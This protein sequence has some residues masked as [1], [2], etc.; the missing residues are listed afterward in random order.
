[1]C[2]ISSFFSRLRLLIGDLHSVESMKACCRY[3]VESE[4][5]VCHV[6]LR[7]SISKCSAAQYS[8]MH[9]LRSRCLLPLSC[10][11]RVI[12]NECLSLVHVEYLVKV[13][14]KGKGV[15]GEGKVEDKDKETC[16]LI[17]RVIHKGGG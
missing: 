1:M 8:G 14:N 3:V 15:E 10:N 5:S 17:S 9:Y 16:E 13:D 4:A 2:G 11:F 12:R 6:M 7:H